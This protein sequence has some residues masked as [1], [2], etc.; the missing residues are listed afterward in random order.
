MQYESLNQLRN[1]DIILRNDI[2]EAKCLDRLSQT[3]YCGYDS[4]SVLRN[5]C[6]IATS[7]TNRY[8]MI[9]SLLRNDDVIVYSFS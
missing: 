9:T 2:D 4:S 5:D 3:V 6:I 8:V 1:G 7:S